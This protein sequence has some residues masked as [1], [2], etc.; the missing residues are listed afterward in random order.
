MI[1]ELP[2]Q[3]VA[4]LGSLLPMTSDEAKIYIPSI[5]RLDDDTIEKAIQMIQNVS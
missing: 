5:T 4:I 2:S 1:W 3:D